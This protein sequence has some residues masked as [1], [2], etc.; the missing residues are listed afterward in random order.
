VK[1]RIQ[2]FSVIEKVRGDERFGQTD[3]GGLYAYVMLQCFELTGEA[4]FIAEAKAAIDAARGL[5]F[6]LVYQTNLTSWGAAACIRLWRVTDDPDYLAQ[7]Y[8]YLAGFFHNCLF[9]ESEIG[10][11]VHYRTFMGATCL[12]DAPYMAM[13]ECFE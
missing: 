11:A 4:R 10:Y 5:R 8:V 6:D 3:V 12:H 1:Y 7:S 2:D 9:W 13:Y